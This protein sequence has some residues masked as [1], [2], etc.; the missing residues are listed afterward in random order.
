MTTNM[1]RKI[2]TIRNTLVAGMLAGGALVVAT[3]AAHTEH[4]RVL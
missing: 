2:L 1:I 4:D 3:H